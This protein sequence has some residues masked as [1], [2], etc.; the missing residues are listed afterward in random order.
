MSHVKTSPL[1]P[2][3]RRKL[4]ARRQRDAAWKHAVLMARAHRQLDEEGPTIR[5][6]FVA[7]IVGVLLILLAVFL[8]TR[9]DRTSPF[10]DPVGAPAEVRR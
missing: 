7:G 9:W 8:I 1:S 5:R 10:A 6:F 2:R 4:H 3:Q